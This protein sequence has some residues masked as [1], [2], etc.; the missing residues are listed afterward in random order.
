MTRG[1]QNYSLTYLEINM[2]K[3]LFAVSFLLGMSINAQ[4]ERPPV[5]SSSQESINNQIVLLPA[6]GTDGLIA[7]PSARR[8]IISYGECVYRLRHKNLSYIGLCKSEGFRKH[9]R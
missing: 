2:K 6:S 5:D 7:K 3:L 1:R 4:A 8:R 9:V